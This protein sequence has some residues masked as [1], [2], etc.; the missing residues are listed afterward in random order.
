[1]R[2]HVS[3]LRTFSPVYSS[4]HMRRLRVFRIA[5]SISPGSNIVRWGS[6]IAGQ[7]VG[8]R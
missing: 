8:A 1:F 5:A 6:A 3:K 2:V 7:I 4:W